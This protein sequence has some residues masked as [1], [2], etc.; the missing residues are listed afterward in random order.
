MATSRYRNLGRPEMTAVFDLDGMAASLKQLVSE[1]NL[2]PLQP[3]IADK[4]SA[5]LALLLR[6]NARINLT[7]IRDPHEILTRHFLESIATAQSLPMDI[8]SLLDVGS[9]AGFPGIPIALCRPEISV[10]L[11]ESQNKKA[12]FLQEVV[13]TLSLTTRVFAGRAETLPERFDC[14]TLRAVDRMTQAVATASDLVAPIGWLAMMTTSTQAPSAQTRL[15]SFRWS[16][17]VTLPGS[18][19]RILAI[20]QKIA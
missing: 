4:F 20:G 11:A 8:R 16:D 13:R 12:A 1:C 19:R 7:A 6:W 10:T 14:V 2:Q 17:P 3:Q 9:G 5:Y 15:A 18:D